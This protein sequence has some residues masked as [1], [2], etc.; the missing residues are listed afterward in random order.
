MLKK[1]PP[2]NMKQAIVDKKI[3]IIP[4]ILDG[5]AMSDIVIVPS[6][7]ID[8]VSII[9]WKFVGEEQFYFDYLDEYFTI[10]NDG[11]EDENFITQDSISGLFSMTGGGLEYALQIPI[12]RKYFDSKD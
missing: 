8:N 3:Y 11:E 1:N 5:A 4:N 6:I 10:G 2:E 7:L 9:N 12:F